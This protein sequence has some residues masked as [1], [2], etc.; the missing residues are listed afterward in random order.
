[1]FTSLFDIFRR[2]EEP[3]KDFSWLGADMHSHLIPGIDDGSKSLDESL[4]LIVELQKLGFRK[5]IT[6]PH[7]MSDYFRNTPENIL[8]GLEQIRQALRDENIDMEIQAAAEYY[9]D[10]GLFRKL[11]EE[12]LLTFGDNYVL[13]EISYINCPDNINDLIFRMQVQGYKPVLA[14]PERYPFWYHDYDKYREIKDLGVVLQLNLNSLSGYYGPE[15]KKLGE[16]LLDDNLVEML[17]TDC[18]H[19]RHIYALKNCL[20]E[21]YV[22]KISE[23]NFLN[24]T[25]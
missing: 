13:F 8:G 12:K 24:S 3:L 25:L 11:D 14:H 6:T 9:F 18:H 10:D 20:K 21:K 2:K 23:G 4:V 5:L 16:H 7:I 22:R 1:M 15:A 17:G 19:E